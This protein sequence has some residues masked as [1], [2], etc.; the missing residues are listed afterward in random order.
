MTRRGTL[1]AEVAMAKNKPGRN[2]PCW[3]GIGRK[4]KQ[5]HLSADRIT[6]ADGVTPLV[7]RAREYWEILHGILPP[8]QVRSEDVVPSRR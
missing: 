7:P 2:A 1:R 5:C 6:E 3:C 4:Y 8:P